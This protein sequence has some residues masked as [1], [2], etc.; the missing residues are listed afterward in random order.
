M[1]G[2]GNYV[3]DPVT[4][5]TKLTMPTLVMRGEYDGIAG[6]DDLLAFFKA[7]PH[8]DKQFAVMQGISHASIQQKNYMTVY[9]ILQ[10][11]FEMPAAIYTAD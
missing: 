3:N 10:C 7:L 4:D 1:C 2:I 11:F 6:M 5:P 8:P 9:H